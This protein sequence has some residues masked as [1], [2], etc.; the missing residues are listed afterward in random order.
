MRRT[1]DWS[2]LC[3]SRRLFMKRACGMRENLTRMQVTKTA[4]RSVQYPTLYGYSYR[5]EALKN[6]VLQSS[7]DDLGFTESAVTEALVFYVAEEQSLLFKQVRQDLM[8]DF[9]PSGAATSFN[10]LVDQTSRESRESTSSALSIWFLVISLS[11]SRR[12]L[13]LTAHQLQEG[14]RRFE[15]ILKYVAFDASQLF[16]KLF[17]VIRSRVRLM[18]GRCFFW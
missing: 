6:F 14:T 4:G 3:F 7:R 2:N 9:D 10:K 17:D 16:R 5:A 18:M 15:R 12:N 11:L 1:L 8:E 13:D